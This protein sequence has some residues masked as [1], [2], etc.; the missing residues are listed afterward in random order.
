MS[1]LIKNVVLNSEEKDILIKGNKI[2]KI[3]D[4]IQA[5]TEHQIDLLKRKNRVQN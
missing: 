3:A 1:I 5:Q 2:S 4:N